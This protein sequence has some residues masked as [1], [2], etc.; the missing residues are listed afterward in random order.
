VDYDDF[1]IAVRA[2]AE[3]RVAQGALV[4]IPELRS[5]LAIDAR[6]FDAHVLRLQHEAL[7]HLLTHVDSDSLPPEVRAGCVPHPSG[8][9]LYWI[10]WL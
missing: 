6:T 9:L 3:T 4:A 2:A 8:I 5:R 7:V 1:K 10:R